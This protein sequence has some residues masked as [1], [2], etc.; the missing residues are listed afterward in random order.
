MNAMVAISM[1]ALGKAF[2][3]G[4][5][6][7]DGLDLDID[8]G[9]FLAVLGPTGSGKSTVLRMIAGVEPPTTGAVLFDGVPVT[10]IPPPDRN[11]T[12]IFANYKLYPNLTVAQNIGFPLRTGP[13]KET[14]VPGRIAEVAE[15]LGIA[16]LLNRMPEHLSGGQQQR[17]AMARAIVR[18]PS[19]LLLDEPLSLVDARMRAEVRAEVAALT[20]RP[21][22]TTVYVTQE[23]EEALS[24][25]DRVAVLR[26]GRLQQVGPPSQ[27]YGDPENVFVAGFLGTPLTSLLQGVIHADGGSVALKLG[28]QAVPLPPAVADRHAEGVTVAVRALRP[29]GTLRGVIRSVRPVGHDVLARVDIGAA[30]S[31]TEPELPPPDE[32]GVYARIPAA[33]RPAVGDRIAL[34][35]AP[36]ELFVFDHSGRRIP[37]DRHS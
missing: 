22:V 11:V 29:G 18:R 36:D 34:G 2:E 32:P 14:D 26:R 3:G 19:V 8:A 31:L 6:A 25:G 24:L 4:V 35:V 10:D 5:V 13:H 12:M 9:E 21:S 37:L 23:P 17:V 15:S 30:A 16:D 7:V 27:V 33:D 1:R 20:R 28:D